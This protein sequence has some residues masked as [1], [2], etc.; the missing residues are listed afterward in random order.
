MEELGN[1]H[2]KPCNPET[3]SSYLLIYKPLKQASP[4]KS[5]DLKKTKDQSY[6][7]SSSSWSKFQQ[8]Y[9]SPLS[10]IVAY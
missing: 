2:E 10:L 8:I 7:K 1:F 9:K 5:F 4:R 3:Y 6:V